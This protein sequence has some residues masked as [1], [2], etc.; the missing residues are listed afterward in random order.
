[1]ERFTFIELFAG[2]G[3]FR[4]GL[5]AIGGECVWACELDALARLVY[6][7]NFGAMPYYD[8]T[9]AD[10]ERLAH[11]DVLTAGFP[12][13]DFSTLG[14]QEGLEGSRGALFFEVIK[15]LRKCK[16][17]CY[18]LENV[19]GLLTMQD[20]RVMDTVVRAIQAEGYSV[21]YKL[22]N[23]SSLVRSSC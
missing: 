1:M 5:E 17:E 10:Y 22:I 6:K 8:V 9:K 13:Q 3:G 18:V 16:P 21:S 4:V 23:S 2:I 15:V 14:D 19:K 7:A 11:F 12:C 20:G